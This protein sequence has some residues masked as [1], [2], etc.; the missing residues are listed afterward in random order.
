MPMGG[1]LQ[2]FTAK[3]PDPPAPS[4]LERKTTMA[5]K[6]SGKSSKGKDRKC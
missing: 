1:P 4:N 3:S 6:K 2:V 5:M